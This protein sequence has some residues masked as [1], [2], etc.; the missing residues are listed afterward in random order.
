MYR[1]YRFVMFCLHIASTYCLNLF[2][3]KTFLCL[4]GSHC[5]MRFVQSRRVDPLHTLGVLSKVNSTQRN[6]NHRPNKPKGYPR[7]NKYIKCS[8]VIISKIVLLLSDRDNIS[9]RKQT[10]LLPFVDS[11]QRIKV[12]KNCL[13]CQTDMAKLV[14][15]LAEICWNYCITAPLCLNLV[16]V[17]LRNGH[18]GDI[19][20][21]QHR[22]RRDQRT[23]V[24][25]KQ[26]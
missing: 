9:V 3:M 19:H 4:P 12:H 10:R 22:G 2:D 16:E 8:I 13:F 25:S 15:A 6:D 21:K 11:S 26:M 20:A 14:K 23:T 7:R 24:P 5:S 1:I 18:L 17:D